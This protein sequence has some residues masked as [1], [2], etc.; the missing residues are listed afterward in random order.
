MIP[1]TRTY[2]PPLKEYHTFLKEIWDKGWITNHGKCVTDLEKKLKKHLGVKHLLCLSNGTLALQVAIKALDL[3]G[4]IITTPFS[5]V[6]TTDSI[7]WEN[8]TPVF[9]DIEPDTLTIDP[10]KVEEAITPRTSAILATH[11]YGNPC[12][13]EALEN[14]ARK[15]DLKIIYDAAHAF[16][17]KYKGKSVLNYGDISTLSFHATKLFHTV[18]GG[19]VITNDPHVNHR[20]S[21]LRNF[22]HNGY[23]GFW[24]IGINAK[25]S[26]VHAAIGLCVLGKIKK[27]FSSRKKATELYFKNLS[28]LNGI[29]FPVL[30]KGTV[31]NYAYFPVLFENEKVL[32]EVFE[33][34]K[35]KKVFPRRYFYPSLNMLPFFGQQSMPVSEN[36]ASRVMCLPLYH[37]I[38]KKDV[39][40]ITAIIRKT[41]ESIT[42]RKNK[43]VL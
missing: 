23:E 26:E 32:L 3:K 6:A 13:V 35:K 37:N 20:N 42:N 1:V 39:D 28:G 10:K 24:G 7:V 5:Y 30:R 29:S 43:K 21:Y 16:G 38:T 17:V 27:I 40:M 15:H 33:A 12:D 2:L 8:C 11:V 4:E 18:E 31:Y 36:A 19:A 25:M 14:I 9:A 34:L 41:L 22:G